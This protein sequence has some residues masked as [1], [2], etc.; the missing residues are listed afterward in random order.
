MKLSSHAESIPLSFMFIAVK[1]T[2]LTFGSGFDATWFKIENSRNF[3]TR[4]TDI[5][6]DDKKMR[7][8]SL[9][10]LDRVCLRVLKPSPPVENDARE[11]N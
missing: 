3:S 1:L 4:P 11:P 7:P 5:I 10:Q 2:R 6:R 8:A 9:R